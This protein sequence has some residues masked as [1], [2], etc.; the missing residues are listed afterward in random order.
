MA[1]IIS[2][3]LN[4]F[5]KR[6][7]DF[8]TEGIVESKE[9][10]KVTM[11]D[12][13]LI[14]EIDADLKDATPLYVTMKEVQT[15]NEK[16][17]LGEQLDRSRFNWELP[18]AENLLYMAIE[19]IISIITGKRREPLVLSSRDTD[20]SKT[21]AEQTQQFLSWKWHDQDMIIKFED[22]VRQASIARIGVFK[23]RFDK[24][25]DDFEIYSLRADRVM[26]DKNATDEYNAKFIAEFREDSLDNLI[27]MFPE[28]KG[29][30]T[31]AYGK[32]KG[33]LINY[34]EYWTNEFVVWKVSNI[35]LDKKKNPNWNWDESERVKNKKGEETG[36][37]KRQ[38]N[39]KE[40][41]KQWIDKTSNEKLENLL[42]NYFNEP[43]KP[44]IILSLKNL[45]KDIYGDTTDFEQGK[46]IQ[47]I[48]N[49]RKRQ[50]DRAAVRGLGR[51]VFSGSFISKEEAK[52][53][54]SNPNS[55]LWLEK[56]KAIDAVTHI[57]PAP[58]S[59][60]IFN[61]LQESKIALDNVMGV[62]GTTRGEQGPQETARGR[63]ILREGDYGRIDLLVRRIDKKLELLYAWML[64]M[65]KVY[66]DEQHYLKMLG[67]EGATIYLKFSRDNIEDGQEIIVK[68]EITVDKAVKR[69]NATTRLQLG[70]SDPLT[71]LEEMDVPKPK[72]LARRLVFYLTDPKLYL[73]QFL[74]DENTEGAE[75][76][77]E[78]RAKKENTQLEAGEQ[79][80][81]YELADKL[82]IETHAERIKKSDFKDL[83][84]E[85]QSNFSNHVRGELD[86]LKQQRQSV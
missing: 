69:E 51:E 53:T 40:L 16:Y 43:R 21:L 46:I 63:T 57:A 17:Y 13:D 82:H 12:E 67:K 42:L 29:K 49:R 68:S 52:K 83:E 20:E 7:K 6:E 31:K 23:L 18:S 80:P 60:V 65:A 9:L 11:N 3:I 5:K 61:D 74:V 55:P 27:K 79:V 32:Q 73:Q 62:H 56:G 47:D 38:K 35:L 85:I 78:G 37:T 26:V 34:V 22:W 44:Y 77:S 24:D 75:N 54:I 28:T 72:E 58:M 10:L 64:Q 45:G 76:T 84:V 50:I 36:Q 30:L 70:L 81:P 59:P 33:T 41:K 71:Y 8:A 25:K 4:R 86:I 2:N 14:R 48:I 1:N 19:T 66:Y 15:E 39:L